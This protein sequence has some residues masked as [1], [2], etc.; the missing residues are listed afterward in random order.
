MLSLIAIALLLSF[1]DSYVTYKRIKLYGA[2]AEINLAIRQL[3]TDF[4]IDIGVTAGLIYNIALIAILAYFKLN[5]TLLFLI[6]A[7]TGLCLMQLKSLQM[8]SVVERAFVK[9]KLKRDSQS[10]RVP[11]STPVATVAD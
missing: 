8:T 7:K 6:G 10:R 4:G 1:I 5:K 11:P 2:F 9:A 3:S